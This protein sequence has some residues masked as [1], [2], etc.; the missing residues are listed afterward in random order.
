M[1]TQLAVTFWTGPPSVIFHAAVVSVS[2]AHA[3]AE[4]ATLH[5]KKLTS[6]RR[7]STLLPA[8]ALGVRIEPGPKSGEDFLGRDVGV[9]AHN[10]GL[11][12]PHQCKNRTGWRT[13]PRLARIG[14]TAA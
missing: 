4:S 3:S 5:S 12:H 6:F 14:P 1:A 7:N 10:D 9:D 13:L 8:G 2:S 11:R